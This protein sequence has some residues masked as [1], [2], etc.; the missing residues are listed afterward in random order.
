MGMEKVNWWFYIAAFLLL[1][2]GFLIL[3]FDVI[4]TDLTYKNKLQTEKLVREIKAERE[5][6]N[7]IDQRF[8]E[9]KYN[10]FDDTRARVNLYLPKL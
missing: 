5:R 10:Y 8:S 4:V 3:R 1:Y 7:H 9:W 6:V 2:V